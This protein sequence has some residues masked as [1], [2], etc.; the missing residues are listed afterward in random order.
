[1]RKKTSLTKTLILCAVFALLLCAIPTIL[2]L[3]KTK[4]PIRGVIQTVS[5]PFTKLFSKAGESASDALASRHQYALLEDQYNDAL[6]EIGQLREQLALLEQLKKENEQLREYLDLKGDRPEWIL[7][8]AE[9]IYNND[10]TG[11]TVTLNK[12]SRH[13]V[14]VGM[15]VISAG[16]LYG[17]VSEVSAST[18]RVTTL[19]DEETFVG[20]R[21]VRSGI[22]AT[23]CG[24]KQGEDYCKLQYLDAGADY[25]TA[26][27]VGD[28]IVTSGYGEKY[29]GGIPIG[30][31][32]SVGVDEY[33]RSPYA[34]VRLY[35]DYS[36]PATLLILLGEK[37]VQGQQS[38]DGEVSGDES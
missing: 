31:I 28:I 23:L 18:C 16:G 7:T 15:P 1:M 9:V 36:S 13:G 29:P 26:L 17:T 22:N 30:E 19:Q 8:D 10:P 35:A 14:S 32:V 4:D 21:V 20:A 33:D 11:K 37:E 5:S 25:K 12:G 24:G 38:S 3:T 2:S 6:D 34:Y 27:A